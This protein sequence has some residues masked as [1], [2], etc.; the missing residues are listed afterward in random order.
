MRKLFSNFQRAL[1]LTLVCTILFASA[2][3]AITIAVDGTKEA[4]WTTG[5]NGQ[6]PGSQTDL[7]EGGITDGYDIEEFLWTNDQ[8]N[9]YFL[10][11]TYASTIWTGNPEPTVI[12]CI[13]TDNNTSTGGSYANCNNMSGIDYS[14]EIFRDPILGLRVIVYQ[15]DPVNGTAVAGGTVASVGDVTEISV[16]L[17]DLGMDSVCQG[18]MRSAI[19]FDNGIGDPD[20]TTPDTGTFELIC[21]SPTAVEVNALGSEGYAVWGIGLASTIAL[22]GAVVVS[23]RR[24]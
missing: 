15:G 2:V 4:V 3:Y 1:A 20:D 10:F 21:G 19:Y 7:N 13:D 11:D 12:L 23:R 9:M 16:A 5:E 8:T 22:L 18:G 24:S 6:T 17:S 14:V